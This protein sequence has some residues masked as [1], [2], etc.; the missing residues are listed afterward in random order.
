MAKRSISVISGST[1]IMEFKDTGDVTFG[2]AGEGTINVS[3]S[4]T[5]GP[6]NNDLSKGI[7][8]NGL[9]R[10]PLFTYE[11]DAAQIAE[12]TS[13]ALTLSLYTSDAADE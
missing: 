5:I 12:L 1:K 8:L 6:P 10:M 4:T 9:V 11:T 7:T 3:G 13:S 2:T